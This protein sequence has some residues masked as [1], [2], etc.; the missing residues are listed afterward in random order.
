MRGNHCR[1]ETGDLRRGRIREDDELMMLEL[2]NRLTYIIDMY[3]YEIY[4]I[5]L[6][7]D[8]LLPVRGNHCR[9]ETGDLRRGRTR[10]DD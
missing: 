7:K 1:S 4:I 10:E 9:S 3:R 6:D 2:D 8:L 5:T